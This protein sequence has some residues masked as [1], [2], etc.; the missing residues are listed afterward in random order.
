MRLSW[1]F[2][3][4]FVY[5]RCTQIEE[6][7]LV[8]GGHSHTFLYSGPPPRSQCSIHFF[9]STR[10]SIYANFVPKSETQRREAWRTIP[11]LRGTRRGKGCAGGAG[12][13]DII[14][15]IDLATNVILMDIVISWIGLCGFHCDRISSRRTASP[16]TSAI[17][18]YSSQA[19]V[20]LHW[21]KW[22][23]WIWIH[24][25]EMF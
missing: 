2:P 21:Y 3:E 17:L 25:A 16:N 7:D 13:N 5:H 11:H 24:L 10:V 20:R 8:V 22:I 18:S 14:F 19:T 12:Q 6:L 1:W 23:N 4:L 15:S 9:V